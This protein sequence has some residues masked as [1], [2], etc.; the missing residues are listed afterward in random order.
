MC[1][2]LEKDS[3]F[4]FDNTCLK[5]FETVTQKLIKTP[6]IIFSDWSN[7]FEVICDA[8]GV[9]LRAV[10]GQRMEKLFYLIFYASKMWNMT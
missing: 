6:V 3:P 8:S 7:Q 9:A 10:L 2:L 4:A 1:K 5:S